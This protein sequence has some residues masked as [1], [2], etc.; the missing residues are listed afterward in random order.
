MESKGI[1]V[2]PPYQS[3]SNLMDKPYISHVMLRVFPHLEYFISVAI[4][5]IA[6]LCHVIVSFFTNDN[7][8]V[9]VCNYDGV[10]VVEK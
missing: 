1:P 2:A 4:S 10:S 6:F 3:H 8:L 5:P 9:L 7:F